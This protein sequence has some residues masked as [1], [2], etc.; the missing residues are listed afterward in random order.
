MRCEVVVPYTFYQSAIQC[1]IL[2]H[3]SRGSMS[4][5]LRYFGLITATAEKSASQKHDVANDTRTRKALQLT[6]GNSSRALIQNAMSELRL[7]MLFKV[8]SEDR[9]INCSASR[10]FLRGDCII[11]KRISNPIVLLHVFRKIFL[12]MRD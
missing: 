2:Q 5:L 7:C 8:R 4:N 12:K 11:N 9:S 3:A 6:S 1:W 10:Q